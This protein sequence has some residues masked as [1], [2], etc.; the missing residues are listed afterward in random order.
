MVGHP[1]RSRAEEGHRFAPRTVAV[2]VPRGDRAARRRWEVVRPAPRSLA[3]APRNPVL[4]S[5]PAVERRRACLERLER[6]ER[7]SPGRG[8]P[9]QGR[10]GQGMPGQGM[11]EPG[12][13]A[14]KRARSLEQAA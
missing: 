6:L 11:P 12:W 9:G 7:G 13:A 3:E 10:P 1:G 14:P 8:S 5:T 2:A 4:R